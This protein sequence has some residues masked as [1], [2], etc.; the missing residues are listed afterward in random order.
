MLDLTH[1]G[2][3]LPLASKLLGDAW[4]LSLATHC[5]SLR[6]VFPQR[7]SLETTTLLHLS[8]DFQI[9]LPFCSVH[10]PLCSLRRDEHALLLETFLPL[11]SVTLH[12]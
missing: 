8:S 6:L 11:T 9:H 3:S 4:S 7:R 1:F 10:Y 5:I 2:D 12:I